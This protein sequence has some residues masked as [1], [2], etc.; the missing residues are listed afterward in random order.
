MARIEA[1][2]LRKVFRRPDKGPGLAGSLRHLVERRYT[3]KAAVDGIS[4]RVDAGEA[5]AY[6]GPNGAGK[7][8]T[9][10]LLTG[11][12]VPTSG[13]VRVN[14][15]VPHRHRIENARGVG[16]VFGQRTSL[17]WD[18]PV[19]ESVELLRDMH[20]LGA[21]EYRENLDRLVEM[22]QIGDL[23]DSTAR[24]LSLGQRMRCDLAA[25]L[26]QHT[27]HPDE[28]EIRAALSGN[29]CRCGTHVEIVR[30]VRKAALLLERQAV[31]EPD[32]VPGAT[33]AN[34][35]LSDAA[36]PNATQPEAY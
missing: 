34:A 26:L 20:G 29:L 16:V 11:I 18:L 6:V 22:L 19:R 4:L 17:W 15:I 10:K 27:P 2:D 7:S 30:A 24:R 25:A 28:A 21:A 9:I 5:V 31:R 8:T 3:E 32:A 35:A 1:D 12:L 14:G 13:E 36:Q 23:L 33:Q